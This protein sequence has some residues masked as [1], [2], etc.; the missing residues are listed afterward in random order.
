MPIPPDEYLLERF[1]QEWVDLHSFRVSTDRSV[2]VFDATCPA[3]EGPV[4]NIPV[5]FAMMCVSGGGEMAQK[6]SRQHF[7]GMLNPGSIG[8]AAPSS[9]GY[10]SW[11][12]M[13]VIG[14]GIHV[15]ALKGSFGSTW[16]DDLSA[17][18]LSKPV[19]DP[20]IEATMMQV[21]YTHADR[22]SDSVMLHAGHRV[23]HQRLDRQTEAVPEGDKSDA[24][25]LPS[26]VIEDVR[27]YVTEH[28]EQT[29]SVEDLAKHLA[30]SRSHF[31]R[32]FR[33]A[34]GETPYQFILDMKLDHAASTLSTSRQTKIIDAANMVGFRNPA[35]F[36]EAFRRR[37]GQSPRKWRL[38][39]M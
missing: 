4:R 2:L 30:I 1:R 25:P 18:V 15:D 9:P 23:V 22:T 29:I 13:R 7:K 10:G 24:Y 17:D 28:I 31:S 32:R 35:R 16:A 6:T 38:G 21:G 39:R 37:F 8:I 34:T 19:R 11:P 26:A 27:A 12:E 14:F 36:A 33:A 3:Q 5:L 20:M